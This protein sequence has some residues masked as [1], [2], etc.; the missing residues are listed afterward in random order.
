MRTRTNIVQAIYNNAIRAQQIQSMGRPFLVVMTKTDH[1]TLHKSARLDIEK[2]AQAAGVE[3]TKSVSITARHGVFCQQETGLKEL[4]KLLKGIREAKDRESV[5]TKTG[6][7][8]GYANA[9]RHFDLISENE[10]KDVIEVIGQA[11]EKTASRIKSTN[12][13]FWLQIFR[14]R[15]RV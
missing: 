8:T 10:L 11:G 5:M 15:V 12:R 2:I 14:K 4:N 6:I 9:M 13:P 7:A 3:M 1:D